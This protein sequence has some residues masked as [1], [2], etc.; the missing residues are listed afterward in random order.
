MSESVGV[1][2][3]FHPG[4]AAHWR[5]DDFDEGGAR[6]GQFA[7]PQPPRLSAFQRAQQ[8]EQN[9]KPARLPNDPQPFDPGQFAIESTSFPSIFAPAELEKG[10]ITSE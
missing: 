2:D 5:E 7:P 10:T 4:A 9:S 3:F 8:E 6:G 1:G